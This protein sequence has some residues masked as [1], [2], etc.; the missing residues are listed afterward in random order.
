MNNRTKFIYKIV[1]GSVII[2]ATIFL[3]FKYLLKGS[4][5]IKVMALGLIIAVVYLVINFIR[6]SSKN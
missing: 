5:F 3:S 2:G 6:K 1:F 4:P